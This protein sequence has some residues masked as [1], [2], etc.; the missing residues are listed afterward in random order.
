MRAVTPTSATTAADLL[1]ATSR[2]VISTCAPGSAGVAAIQ[3]IALT[4][5]D[6]ATLLQRVRG[7]DALTCAGCGGQTRF[8]AV[9]TDRAASERASAS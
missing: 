5:W 8:I 4:K 6:R 7:F 9:I 1:A 3:Q 2:A